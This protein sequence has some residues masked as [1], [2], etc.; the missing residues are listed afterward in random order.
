MPSSRGSSLPT[1]VWTLSQ[2][3][4]FSSSVISDSATPWKA[5]RQASCKTKQKS[6]EHQWHQLF[7]YLKSLHEYISSLTFE[8]VI[9]GKKS[10]SNL[11]K[12]NT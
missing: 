6:N 11:S 2:S 3:V 7:Y 4:Q 5:A 8:S 12:Q 10:P 1:L 9:K